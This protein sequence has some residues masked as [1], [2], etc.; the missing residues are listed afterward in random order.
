MIIKLN[1]YD[2]T[3]ERNDAQIWGEEREAALK[4]FTEILRTWQLS[5][6]DV[7]PQLLDFSLGDFYKYGLIEYWVANEEKEGYCGKFLF[8]FKG[9]TCPYHYHAK[10]HETFFVVKGTITMN[11]E[12][13]ESE[14]PQG[15][16]VALD[17]NKS[18]S[19]TGLTD[20]LILE[21]SKPCTPGDNFFKD[22]NVGGD[23]R[24]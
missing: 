12:G 4:R 1:H 6:P 9:Q 21:V 10:K 16:L 15:S 8:L 17:Q 7:V 19:F 13:V 22:K 18:H 2:F 14:H 24:L 11:I 23:G 3:L 5:M 20:A